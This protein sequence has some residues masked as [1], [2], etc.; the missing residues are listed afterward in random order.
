M[1]QEVDGACF[2]KVKEEKEES[3]IYHAAEED[4]KAAGFSLLDMAELVI[5]VRALLS[6]ILGLDW[7]RT[8]LS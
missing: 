2:F 3:T 5:G 8:S 7:T 6:S 1:V 4:Y